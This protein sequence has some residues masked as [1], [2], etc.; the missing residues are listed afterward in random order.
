M[1]IDCPNRCG[2]E[3]FERCKFSDHML[4]CPHTYTTCSFGSIGCDVKM[5]LLS[6]AVKKHASD[7]LS[8]HLLLV[9]QKNVELL[10]DF[11][12]FCTTL[13]SEDCRRSVTN[14]EY[15]IESQ[16][17]ALATT[18]HTIKSLK[19]NLQETQKKT[20]TLRSELR[21]EEISLAEIKKR[22]TQIKNVEATC[23]ETI[24]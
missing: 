15:F 24:A 3:Q 1:P 4:I 6:P 21:K 14:D 10:K 16:R 17:E 23:Q 5:P 8:K 12:Q 2:C 19:E 7:C 22:V 13:Q 18:K 9:A 20:A 11:R